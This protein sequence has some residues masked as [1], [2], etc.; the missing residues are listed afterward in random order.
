MNSLTRF[1]RLFL[2]THP[3]LN[4]SVKMIHDINIENNS[5]NEVGLYYE[6]MIY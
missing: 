2:N 5:T 3:T 1:R 4:S 6:F